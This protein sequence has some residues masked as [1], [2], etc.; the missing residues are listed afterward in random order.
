MWVDCCSALA[1]SLVQ[2]GCA[3]QGYPFYRCCWHER[4]A[5]LPPAYRAV[6]VLV[7]VR[8]FG[9][10]SQ[11]PA[12]AVPRRWRDGHVNGLFV[13]RTVREL[14]WGY[15]DPLLKGKST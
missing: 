10:A 1:C 3:Q 15:D 2:W 7:A 14:L 5:L 11:L 6:D 4:R 8:W 12:T 9:F 13:R